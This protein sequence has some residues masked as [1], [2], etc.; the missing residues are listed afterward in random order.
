MGDGVAGGFEAADA[1]SGC[2]AGG[3]AGVDVETEGVD[4]GAAAFGAA[5]AGCAF[6]CIKDQESDF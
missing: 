1:A 2:G 4:G 6:G 3:V 5:A